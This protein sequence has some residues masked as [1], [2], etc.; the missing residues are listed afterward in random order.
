MPHLLM[1]TE[2]P[3]HKVRARV[4]KRFRLTQTQTQTR[5]LTPVRGG[6][7]FPPTGCAVSHRLGAVTTS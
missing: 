5:I 1:R 3:S 7:H 2:G 4:K 6:R